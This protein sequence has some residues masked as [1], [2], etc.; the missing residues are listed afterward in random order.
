MVVCEAGKACVVGRRSHHQLKGHQ[1]V[2]RFI[3]IDQL[4][5]VAAGSVFATHLFQL[6]VIYPPPPRMETWPGLHSTLVNVVVS[7]GAFG[8]GLFFV[9]SGLCIHLPFARALAHKESFTFRPTAYFKRRFLR[10]YPPHAVILLVSAGL[11]IL[12]D[13]QRFNI[14]DRTL[15]VP[16]ISQ[17]ALHVLMLH[18]FRP[19]AI[20]SINGVLW[21]IALETHFYLLY[22]LVV[23]LRRRLSMPTICLCM[24]VLAIIAR[25]IKRYMFPQIDFIVYESFLGRWWE[26]GLGCVIA[27]RLV[28]SDLRRRANDVIA[29]GV[30][31]LA[32]FAS[33]AAPFTTADKLVSQFMCP[34]LFGWVTLLWAGREE[35]PTSSASQILRAVGLRSYSLYLTHPVAFAL[36]VALLSPLRPSPL[37]EVLSLFGAGLVIWL[38]FYRYCETP[39]QRLARSPT[40]SLSSPAPSTP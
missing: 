30:P 27:E 29:W 40:T 23:W 10:I 21:T 3:G 18:S 31:A 20:Y 12:I 7:L 9:L 15:S 2:R 37:V 39:F 38:L 26:W 19:W 28:A 14:P 1:V 25:A 24:L 22:P 13:P 8:V 6:V 5:A 36:A 34:L 11:A 33:L 35:T 17:F 16:T 4:R 32:L